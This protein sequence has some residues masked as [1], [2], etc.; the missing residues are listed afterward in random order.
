MRD[1]MQFRGGL[2]SQARRLFV[3]L[4][5]RPRVIKKEKKVG[6]SKTRSSHQGV[7]ATTQ[8]TTQGQIDGFFS[9]LPFKCHPPEVAAVGH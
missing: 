5:S 4:I 8:K 2:V 3:A 1:A 9:Q 6:S 7:L